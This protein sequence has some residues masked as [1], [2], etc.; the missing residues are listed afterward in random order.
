MHNKIPIITTRQ[1]IIILQQAH[2]L[3]PQV[4]MVATIGNVICIQL[5]K[6]QDNDDLIFHLRQLT[7]VCAT[8]GK[9][10]NAIKLQYF[11][12]SLE[13]RT[14]I[15]FAQY[16]ITTPTWTWNE[17]Q[18]TFIVKFNEVQCEDQAMGTLCYVKQRKYE[19]V[20]D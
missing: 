12:N 7:K 9:D 17:I 3:V 10:I 14:T 2:P 15:W 19:L 6:D 11:P 8:N 18:Q 16:E 5:P 13:G 1:S 20:E 4:I